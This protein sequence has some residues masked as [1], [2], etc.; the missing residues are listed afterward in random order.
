MTRLGGDT[1]LRFLGWMVVGL[2]VY[3]PTAAREVRWRG[4]ADAATWHAQ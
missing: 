1:W 4:E 2:M 3:F